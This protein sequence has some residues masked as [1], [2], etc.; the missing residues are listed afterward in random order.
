MLLGFSGSRA[1]K[2]I[3]VNS[4]PCVIR[5]IL[6]FHPGKHNQGL[7]HDSLLTSLA[8]CNGSIYYSCSFIKLSQSSE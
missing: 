3:S 6:D 1:T 4:Q 7:C 8:R 2:C 5:P